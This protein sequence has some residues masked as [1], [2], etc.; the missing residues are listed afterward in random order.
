[1]SAP[2][3]IRV[4]FPRLLLRFRPR[5]AGEELEDAGALVAGFLKRKAF[6]A[7]G[8]ATTHA[9][10]GE[11]FD[12]LAGM[13]PARLIHPVRCASLTAAP[14]ARPSGGGSR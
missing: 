8:H 2:P 6:V 1:M 10:F 3:R 4:H 13:Y 7:V 12:V 9:H 5:Q 14:Q 11:R